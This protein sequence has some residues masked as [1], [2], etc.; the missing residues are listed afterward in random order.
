MEP[1][2]VGS[3][4]KASLCLR[5][6]DTRMDNVQNCDCYIYKVFICKAHYKHRKECR[7]I[8]ASLSGIRTHDLCSSGR[9]DFLRCTPRTMKE[10]GTEFW[11]EFE[12]NLTLLR[13]RLFFIYNLNQQSEFTFYKLML[14]LL[15]CLDVYVLGWP[16]NRSSRRHVSWFYSVFNGILRR[17]LSYKSLSRAY[18][19]LLMLEIGLNYTPAPE[20]TKLNFNIKY[21]N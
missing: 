21:Q 13:T 12:M 6:E 20:D 5:S 8:P 19:T 15:Q 2:Q 11:I 9:R 10:A 18:N 14:W 17:F 3:I 16:Y 4:D 7:H 1:V